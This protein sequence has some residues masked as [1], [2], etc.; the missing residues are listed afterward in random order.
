MFW[1]TDITRMPCS[2]RQ[3]VTVFTEELPWLRGRD[4]EL[5]K[6]DA[7]CNWVGWRFPG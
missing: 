3:C 6:G 1:G 2:W 4:L 5:V 7:L